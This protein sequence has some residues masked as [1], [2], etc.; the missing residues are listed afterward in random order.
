MIKKLFSLAVLLCVAASCA[1]ELDVTDNLM[2]PDEETPVFYATIENGGAASTKVYADEELRVLWNKNDCISI[3]NLTTGNQKFRF[4]GGDGANA[5]GFALVSGDQTATA[6]DHIYALYP[7]RSSTA[8]SQEGV[9][10]LTLPANQNYKQDSFGIDANTMLSVSDNNQL[11]FRNVCGY[12]RFN[13]YGNNVNI[14][15][16]TIRGNN[17]EPL[18][19]AATVTM[20]LNGIPAIQMAPNAT[21]S[22]T[23]TC[24]TPVTIGTSSNNPTAFYFV[25]PPTTFTKG[26]SVTVLDDNDGIYEIH[27]AQE[28]TIQ[29]SYLTKLGAKQ[30][31]PVRNYVAFEDD[32]FKT[33]CVTNFDTNQDGQISYVEALSVKT[34]NVKADNIASLGGIEHF[35]NLTS[36]SCRGTTKYNS[37]T[38]NYDTSGQLTGADLSGNPSLTTLNLSG[39]KL[40][41]LQIDNCTRLNSLNVSNNKLTSLNVSK[42]VSLTYLACS[43]NQLSGLDVSQNTALLSLHCYNNRLTSLNVTNN[44]ALNMLQCGDNQLT[45]LDVSKNADMELLSCGNNLLSS[46]NVSSNTALMEL[47]CGGNQLSAL[48]VSKNTALQELDCANNKL[49]NLDVSKNTELTVLRCFNNPIT[50][51]D[52]RNNMQLNA[53][54]CYSYP[55]NT[56]QEIWLTVGQEIETFNYNYGVELKYFGDDTPLVFTNAAFKDWC[57]SQY[58]DNHDGEISLAEAI[59]VTS[60]NVN[61]DNITSLADIGLFTNLKYLTCTG[62]TEFD[63][64]L[65]QWNSLGQLTSLDVSANTKL[66]SLSCGNNQLTSLTVSENTELQSLNCSNNKLSSLDISNN[67]ELMDLNCDDNPLKTLDISHNSNLEYLSCQNNQLTGLSLTDNLLLR[68][69]SCSHNQL[70]ALDLSKNT[71]LY[72]LNCNENQL[73]ALDLSNNTALTD[74]TCWGNNL[75]SLIID[76]CTLLS[77]LQCYNNPLTSLDVSKNTELT[78][79]YC[80]YTQLTELDVSNNLSLASLSCWSCPQLTTIWF[81]AGQVPPSFFQYD[82]EV[83]TIRYK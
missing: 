17:D 29:R 37:Q 21:Q 59:G 45:G 14:K 53:L 50:I 69:F 43:Y 77:E 52:V 58:D 4:T 7:Y 22:I 42:N 47:R 82:E 3:F 57:V 38:H 15:S 20:P 62:S 10:S 81:K 31:T 75:N 73:T 24:E 6:I 63:G 1:N 71:E 48:D 39:N 56:F 60:M 23:L 34:I 72:W 54:D 19:G 35:T 9:L 26:I 30:V 64:N 13:F 67:T 2:T 79:L 51:L 12:L 40:T 32:N 44:T 76:K 41:S 83:A 68:S 61:T 78:L 27:S 8:I 16:I 65:I 80:S 66:K 36:L 5:G 70:T 46:L 74:V 55:T 18:A 25:I 28:F 49:N 11:M 33:Y